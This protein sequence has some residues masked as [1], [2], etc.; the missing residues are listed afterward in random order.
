MRI[1]KEL[2]DANILNEG[3]ELTYLLSLHYNIVQ[4]ITAVEKNKANAIKYR[5]HQALVDAES[6]IFY[7]S[8][9]LE[10][11]ESVIASKELELFEFTEYGEICLN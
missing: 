1:D 6:A 7:L 8:R 9:N 2:M 4:F 3:F 11:V 5:Q 10:I